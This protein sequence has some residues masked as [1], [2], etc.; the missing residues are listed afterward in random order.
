LRCPAYQNLM[1]LIAGIDD[2]RVVEQ[3]SRHLG[4]WHDPPPE[5]PPSEGFGTYAYEPC[6][7]MDPMPNHENVLTD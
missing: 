7:D 6:Q 1:R 2:R 3:I 5:R 4:A